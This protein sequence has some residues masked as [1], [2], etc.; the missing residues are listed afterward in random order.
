MSGRSWLMVKALLQAVPEDWSV[1]HEVF[2]R[3]GLDGTVVTD[4]PPTI[5]SY[6]GPGEESAAEPLRID[7]FAAG[8]RAVQAEWVPEVDWAEAW[9]QFFVPR[10][11][12]RFFVRPSWEDAPTPTGLTEI[13]LDPGQ[14]FGTGDH[15][16]TRM[17]LVLVG[18]TVQPDQRV[19]DVGTG[20]GIL[21]IAAAKLG[22]QVEGVDVDAPSVDAARENAARNA[23][24][25]V[26]RLGTGFEPLEGT[27]DVVLSNI[28]SA[29]LIGLAPVAA[30]RVRPG[31]AWVVSGIIQENWPDVLAAAEKVGFRLDR[32]LEEGE[33]V[34]ARLLR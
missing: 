1:W 24:E 5:S 34:A 31:G 8:A 19:A 27:Y 29:A 22:A 23:V 28:I 11:V 2:A 9:K 4:D 10:E 12:G 14:A 7:L 21:S 6:L 17:C 18:E 26:F 25:A 15:P 20:S 33:W 3:H 30:A 32:R 16:T 13:V